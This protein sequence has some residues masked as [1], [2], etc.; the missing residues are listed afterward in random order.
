MLSD[1]RAVGR[2]VYRLSEGDRVLV[3][4]YQVSRFARK[5]AGMGLA[6]YDGSRDSF[7]T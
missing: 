5:V 7:I 1:F 2:V 6:V 4:T 3:Q